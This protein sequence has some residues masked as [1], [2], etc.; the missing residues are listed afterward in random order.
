MQVDEIFGGKHL[1]SSGK[2]ILS[3]QK[4][5]NQADFGDIILGYVHFYVKL[6]AL[7]LRLDQYILTVLS[8]NSNA[9]P[10]KKS[11]FPEYS[12]K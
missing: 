12:G 10:E 6:L 7:D 5:M 9:T 4:S 2:A 11:Y 3:L 8:V 1:S